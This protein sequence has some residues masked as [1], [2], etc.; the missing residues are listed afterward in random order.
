MT[1]TIPSCDWIRNEYG[2]IDQTAEY[3]PD[4]N[5]KIEKATRILNLAIAH[6]IIQ[7]RSNTFVYKIRHR[8][9]LSYDLYD[10]DG[11]SYLFQFRFFTSDRY[12]HRT[13]LD[14]V[15][16][17][18]TC[19]PVNIDTPPV[20]MQLKARATTSVITRWSKVSNMPGDLITRALAYH[21]NH[22]LKAA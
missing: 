20:L 10:V 2:A 13:H 11:D 6:K 4:L 8:Q 19:N 15:Y 14:K 5:L 18:L 9:K 3:T 1:S 16:F 21:A 12:K 7:D 22:L 17:L